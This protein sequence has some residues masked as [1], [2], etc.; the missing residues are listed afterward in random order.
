MKIQ[1]VQTEIEEAVRDFIR[2]QIAVKEGMEITMDFSATRGA[3]GLIAAIDISPAPLPTVKTT[4]RP[5]TT[6]TPVASSTSSTTA[7][8]DTAPAPKDPTPGTY[9]SD[10]DTETDADAGGETTASSQASAGDASADAEEVPGEGPL[11][12]SIFSGLRRP[13]NGAAEEQAH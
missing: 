10:A 7:A 3:E 4:R 8:A 6:S 11:K 1:I 5:T 2:K 13:A 9:N 12:P